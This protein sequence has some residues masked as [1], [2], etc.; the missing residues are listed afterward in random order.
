MQRVSQEGTPAFRGFMNR[1]HAQAEGGVPGLT[2][3]Q[4]SQGLESLDTIRLQA[5]HLGG[6]S[7]PYRSTSTQGRVSELACP[8][9]SPTD[10]LLTGRHHGDQSAPPMEGGA[11]VL[12]HHTQ[13]C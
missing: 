8:R 10:I 5:G 9:D 7:V 2:H 3:Q 6:R 13:R 11:S 4:A 1:G 12:A